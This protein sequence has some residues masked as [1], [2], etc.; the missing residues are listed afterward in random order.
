MTTVVGDYNSESGSRARGPIPGEAASAASKAGAFGGRKGAIER[1]G[2]RWYRVWPMRRHCSL[3][4]FDE[5]IFFPI[6]PTEAQSTCPLSS[7]NSFG[8]FCK[9]R[10][11]R[12]MMSYISALSEKRK[13]VD[14]T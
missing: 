12:A 1:E 4:C 9:G 7:F 2:E 13:N 6:D 10:K 5:N 11:D 14:N 8:G 3:N